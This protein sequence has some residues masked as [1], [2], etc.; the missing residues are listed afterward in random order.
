MI[1]NNNNHHGQKQLGRKGFV[2]LTLP[3]NSSPLKEVRAGI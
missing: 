3:G 1:K 2:L